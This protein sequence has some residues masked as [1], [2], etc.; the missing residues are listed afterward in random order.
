LIDIGNPTGKGIW[1]NFVTEFKPEVCGFGT[2]TSDLSMRIGYAP[3]SVFWKK[4][5]GE[6][7]NR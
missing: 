3:Q 7:T 2:S 6:P 1:R 5:W 4:Q